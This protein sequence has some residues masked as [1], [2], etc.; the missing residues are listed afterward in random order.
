[1]SRPS[2]QHRLSV[3]STPSSLP[4]RQSYSRTHSSSLAGAGRISKNKADGSV[5]INR[6]NSKPALNM[7]NESEQT[8]I[9][10]SLPQ[11]ASMPNRTGSHAGVLTDGPSL[12][13][14]PVVDKSKAKRRASD[15]TSL[16]KK[17]RAATGELK[18][19]HCGKAYKHGSCLQK[20]L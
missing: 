15:G 2:T 19:D 13:S 5:S 10:S 8:P 1:M 4:A 11:Q 14:F 17:D 3:S 12:S 9:P 16:S 7:L 18:C 6:R 20:H